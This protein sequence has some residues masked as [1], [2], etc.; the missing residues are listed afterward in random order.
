MEYVQDVTGRKK[1]EHLT[2]TAKEIIL[3]LN[4]LEK[5]YKHL[6]NKMK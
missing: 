5:Y 2:T 4:T 1:R 3:Y 6:Y